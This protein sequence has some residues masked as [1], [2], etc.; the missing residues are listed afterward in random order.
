[1]TSFLFLLVF[2]H[3]PQS[4][5]Q[6]FQNFVQDL[7]VVLPSQWQKMDLRCVC[8][9]KRRARKRMYEPNMRV[10][11]CFSYE[12]SMVSKRAF[13]DFR[14]FRGFS[15]W[16]RKFQFFGGTK[17]SLI[18]RFGIQKIGKSAKL[19]YSSFTFYLP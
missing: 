10:Q 1:M 11:K 3:F 19:V 7:S 5:D 9:G 15:C 13:R 6:F 8:S 4:N 16:R 2:P 18:P 12:I 17:K 14:D